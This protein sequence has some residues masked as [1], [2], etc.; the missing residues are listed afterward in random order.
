M[1]KKTS[2]QT[3][4]I[5]QIVLVG[6]LVV[7]AFAIGMMWSQLQALKGGKTGLAQPPTAQPEEITELTE[8]QWQQVLTNPAATW[9]SEDAPVTMVEFTDYQCPFCERHFTETSGLIDQNYID[10]GKVRYVLRDLPLTSLG[11]ANAQPAAEAAR[12]A[13][14]QNQYRAYHDLLFTN[15]ADWAELTNPAATFKTYAG[16]LNLNASQFS[17][18]YDSRKYQAA[19]EEDAALANQVGA[20]GTPTFIIN[21]QVIVG[22]Q[23]YATFQAALDQALSQ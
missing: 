22:A 3:P 11:H 2:I 9:G 10:P 17:S 7:A 5:L 1:A 12:C 13:G 19:V 16:Q 23:A 6:L 20:S 14:E 15:Q 4:Q 21:R 8:A 18:C